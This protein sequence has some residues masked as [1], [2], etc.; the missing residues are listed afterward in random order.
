MGL[1]TKKK[2]LYFE[3]NIPEGVQVKKD[4]Y[5]AIVEGPQGSVKK[6]LRHPLI[7]WSVEGNLIKIEPKKHTKREKK[8]M[9]TFKSHL[10]NMI[11]GV[12]E[13][14]EYVLKICSGHFPMTVTKENDSIKIKNF[15][16]E[17]IPRIAK[18]VEGTEVKID[19]DKV[20]IHSV[21]KEAAGQTAGNIEKATRIKNRDERIFQDGIYIINK[22][23]K[24]IR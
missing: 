23:G 6:T 16:G 10:I 12:Q 20:I 7:D 17:K 4:G 22:C 11:L 24:D 5:D 14:F 15:L 13:K 18:I 21:N 9:G 8:I 3:I 19:G 1:G 2:E